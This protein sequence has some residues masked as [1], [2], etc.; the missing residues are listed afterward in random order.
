MSLYF[1]S[2]NYEESAP[3]PFLHLPTLP[4][5]QSEIYKEV[6]ERCPPFT[7]YFIIECFIFFFWFWLFVDHYIILFSA[8]PRQSQARGGRNMNG[9]CCSVF[10]PICLYPLVSIHF[11]SNMW[12]PSWNLPT[13]D[14]Y[15]VRYLCIFRRR[16]TVHV[17]LRRHSG[18]RSSKF[19]SW[20]VDDRGYVHMFCKWESLYWTISWT[21]LQ[22]KPTMCIRS[23]IAGAIWKFFHGHQIVVPVRGTNIY[24]YVWT[25]TDA[26][27]NLPP[28]VMVNG[29]PGLSHSYMI[30]MKVIIIRFILSACFYEVNLMIWLCR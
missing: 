19:L 3:C 27:N 11:D 6:L 1:W 14:Q 7:S 13:H 30:N 22:N 28:V 20:L 4:W 29:G 26:A 8:N 25:N 9:D 21:Y 24:A 10:S 18:F 23:C 5:L 12:G 2:R 16:R 17:Y 15:C